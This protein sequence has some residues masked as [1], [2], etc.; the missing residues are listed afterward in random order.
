MKLAN[1]M[2]I[3]CSNIVK[4][5]VECRIIDCNYSHDAVEVQILEGTWKGNVTVV[6][7]DHIEVIDSIENQI[8]LNTQSLVNVLNEVGYDFTLDGFGDC[9][10][11]HLTMFSYEISIC[12]DDSE[13]C[14]CTKNL[15]RTEYGI[16]EDE[17]KN[18]KTMKKVKTVLKYIDKYDK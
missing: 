13:Y 14:A 4:D 2:T 18:H 3:N 11:I 15:N 17:D 7:V 12:I 10:Y 5:S 1:G 16:Y 8:A 6:S 9:N